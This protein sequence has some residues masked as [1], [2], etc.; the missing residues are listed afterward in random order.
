MATKTYRI[1]KERD[2]WA[3]SI[4]KTGL[5]LASFDHKHQAE[6]YR[7]A[8]VRA[9]EQSAVMASFNELEEARCMLGELRAE[10][11]ELAEL[12]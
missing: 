5:I 3:V 1:S 9:D 11:A 12:A 10:L 2:G 7:A 8:Q 6:D 4:R